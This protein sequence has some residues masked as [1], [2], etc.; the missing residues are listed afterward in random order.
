MAAPSSL[1]EALGLLCLNDPVAFQAATETL[2][3]IVQNVLANPGEAKYRTLRRKG[4]AFAQ[5]VGGAK[6]GVRAALGSEHEAC[7][8]LRASRLSLRPCLRAL[9]RSC[10]RRQVR[11]LRAVGFVDEGEGDEAA[12]T[13]P[14][15]ADVT[16]LEGGKA[17]LKACVKERMQEQLRHGEQERQRENA[18]A[19]GK[20]A[21][22][23]AVSKQNTAQRDQEAEVERQRVL[24]GIKIVRARTPFGAGWLPLR[25]CARGPP[26]CR[27]H[28]VLAS[29][30]PI[31]QSAAEL[32]ARARARA[33]HHPLL[34]RTA[35]I[36]C[37]SATP[38]M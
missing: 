10:R 30:T 5:K 22:L 25:T 8:V 18:L 31:A 20:L 2:F 3:K 19:A 27:A 11:F 4:A 16:L 1:D 28:A 12:L 23:R 26:T 13:L 36:G 29:C 17:A 24:D 32:T 34:R 37:D 6:G 7:S 21:E 9:T 38:T 14:A 15:A 35:T 33:R